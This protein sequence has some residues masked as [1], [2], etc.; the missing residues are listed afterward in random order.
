V[1]NVA[2]PTS[3]C[4]QPLADTSL[5]DALS[6][7]D[8]VI[9]RHGPERLLAKPPEKSA[10]DALAA[11]LRDLC[12]QARRAKN[13]GAERMVIA[14]HAAWPKLSAVRR[15]SPRAQPDALLDCIVTL[16]IAE[17]YAPTPRPGGV[18][19][20]LDEAGTQPASPEASP[21]QR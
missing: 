15:L 19:D 4:I 7:L 12:T 13:G 2:R 18:M 21:G 20:S 11:V 10:S 14:L 9:A 6:A 3:L 5:G 16:A 17:F 8:R 1:T